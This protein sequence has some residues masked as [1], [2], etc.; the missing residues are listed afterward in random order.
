MKPAAIPAKRPPVDVLAREIA[1]QRANGASMDHIY[2]FV[3]KVQQK[4][5]TQ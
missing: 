1:I 3:R 5:K 4:E 2:E